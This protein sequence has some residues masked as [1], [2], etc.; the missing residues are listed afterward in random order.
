LGIP[1]AGPS[2]PTQCRHWPKTATTVPSTVFFGKMAKPPILEHIKDQSPVRKPEE[3][4]SPNFHSVGQERIAS[5]IP[6]FFQ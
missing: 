2:Q 5:A 3:D 6:K 1:E 4:R